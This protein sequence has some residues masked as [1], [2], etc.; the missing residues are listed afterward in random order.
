MADELRRHATTDSLTGIANRRLFDESLQREW[1]RSRRK[2]NPLT[3]L[4]IDVDHFKLYNDRYGHP[5]GDACLQQIAQALQSSV[6]RTA[7]VLARCGGEEFGV[8][9]PETSRSG[10]VH[11]AQRILA[12]VA[13]SKVRHEASPT[14]RHVSV[15]IGIGCF[16]EL[17]LC[18]APPGPTRLQLVEPHRRY[19]G[20]DLLLAADNALYRAKR[21]GRAQAQLLD[22]SDAGTSQQDLDVCSAV[23]DVERA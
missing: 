6:R 14:S 11:V 12:A 20:N 13:A 5:K 19:F 17:S 8:L 1:L 18:W 4:L 2:A 23:G 7:D 22:I 9:L 16:D 3:L 21:A 15:S 10:G